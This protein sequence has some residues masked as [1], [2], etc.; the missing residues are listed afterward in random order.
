MAT[1]ARTTPDPVQTR[2][3]PAIAGPTNRAA[4]KVADPS[5]IAAAMSCFGTSAW[6]SAIRAGAV[7]DSSDPINRAETST[8]S[9]VMTP[10]MVMAAKAAATIAVAVWATSV[11]RIYPTRSAIAPA[12]TENTTSGKLSA[13]AMMPSQVVD[14]VSSQVS[15]PT[16]IRYIQRPM[17][18][19]PLLDQYSR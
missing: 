2:S 11:M 1:T 13:K 7:R 12:S 3:A 15:Q 8:S 6:T 18:L 16:A 17:V 9:M 4:L 19:M 5:A 14:S 10:A